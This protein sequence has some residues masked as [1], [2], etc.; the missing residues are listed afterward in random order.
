[1]D[2]PEKESVIDFPCSFPIKAMG[3][4]CLEFDMLVYSIVHKHAPDVGEGAIKTRKSTK[5]KYVSVT[6]TINAQSREQLDNIY[7][8]LSNCEKV[9]MA[10]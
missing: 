7:Q 10:L 8:D 6:I 4:D 3:L 2:A 9:L 1:M 5:G